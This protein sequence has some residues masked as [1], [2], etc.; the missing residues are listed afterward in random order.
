MAQ[1]IKFPLTFEV[2]L[3]LKYGSAILL[4]TIILIDIFDINGCI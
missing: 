4:N 1:S 3:L 2:R